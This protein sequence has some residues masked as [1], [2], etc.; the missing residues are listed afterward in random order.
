[1]EQC[2]D[3]KVTHCKF[4][5]T[6]RFQMMSFHAETCVSLMPLLNRCKFLWFVSTLFKSSTL[7]F[8]YL[9]LL[10]IPIT[11]WQGLRLIL[12]RLF[13]HIM[14]ISLEFCIIDVGFGRIFNG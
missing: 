9:L 5:L 13:S 7:T 11:I 2:S 12:L 6:H 4:L 10:S 3:K 8:Y 14:V 1:M